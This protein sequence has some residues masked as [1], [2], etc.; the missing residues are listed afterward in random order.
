MPFYKIT[1]SRTSTET[2][3][4]QVYGDSAEGAVKFALAND[5][6]LGYQHPTKI[7]RRVRSVN[8]Q[9]EPECPSYTCPT[10]GGPP[11][12]LGRLGTVY[13]LRCRDCG[14]NYQG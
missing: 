13:H 11:Q 5:D 2:K 7:K 3:T 9:A 12:L 10:C 8:E 1:I 4:F 6:G 14:I